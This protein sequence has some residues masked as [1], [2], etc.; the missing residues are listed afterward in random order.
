MP[1]KIV[2]YRYPDWKLHE[3]E[4]DLSIVGEGEFP[5]NFHVMLSQKIEST[6]IVGYTNPKEIAITKTYHVEWKEFLDEIRRF[7]EENLKDV[8]FSVC[9]D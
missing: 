8:D 5:K 3:D 1:I 9:T 6:Y 4:F 7:L 2:G